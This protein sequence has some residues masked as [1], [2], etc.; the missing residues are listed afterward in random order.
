MANAPVNAPPAIISL[1]HKGSAANWPV[2]ISMFLIKR[3]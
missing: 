1:A 3:F 2:F